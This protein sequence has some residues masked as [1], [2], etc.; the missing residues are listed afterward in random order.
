MDSGWI[1]L[2]STG[3]NDF[4]VARDDNIKAT[5]K[6]VLP[7][8]FETVEIAASEEVEDAMILP[9]LRVEEVD[10]NTSDDL[11]VEPCGAEDFA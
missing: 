8:W 6:I 4:S 7:G 2:H 5:Q 10:D 3:R 1:S 11:A 9:A